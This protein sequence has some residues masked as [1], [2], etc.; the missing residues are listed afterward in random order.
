MSMTLLASITDR[1]SLL[2]VGWGVRNVVLAGLVLDFRELALCLHVGGTSRVYRLSH[3][4]VISAALLEIPS[5]YIL[6]GVV[7]VEPSGKYDQGRKDV[8]RTASSV[9]IF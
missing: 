2:H 8:L 3:V 9:L 7:V 1:A 5:P 6:H 4:L